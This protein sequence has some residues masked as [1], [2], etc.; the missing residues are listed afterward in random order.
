VDITIHHKEMGCEDAVG[1]IS[2]T[3]DLEKN[4]KLG[5]HKKLAIS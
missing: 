4:K 3:F 2:L 5:I 1:Y